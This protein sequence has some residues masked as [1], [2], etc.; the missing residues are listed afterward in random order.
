MRNKTTDRIK[1]CIFGIVFMFMSLFMVPQL[2]GKYGAF[3]NTYMLI[4]LFGIIVILCAVTVAVNKNNLDKILKLY[5]IEANII[6]LFYVV[7]YSVRAATGRESFYTM[8]WISCGFLA[9]VGVFTALAFIKSKEKY[10]IINK[11]WLAFMPT[12]AY[13][14]L[15]VFLRKPNTYYELNLTLG[16]GILS[17]TDYL[18]SAF[19]N[20]FW[21][22]FNF[23]GNVVFFIPLVFIINA[24][25]PKL[26]SYQ[27]F[28]ISCIVPYL[29]EGYQFIF[30]CGSVDIDD[31]VLNTAG[32]IIGMLVLIISRKKQT[33]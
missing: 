2:S 25:F 11:F 9:S 27:A 29:V 10:K 13:I 23:V 14:F 33:M 31:I 6:L 5:C 20:D 28:I 7:D 32:I 12:Y 30:K 1:I 8:L 24:F 16:N 19:K 21:M 17:Y 22:A 18:I 3:I 26:K 4:I 15:I